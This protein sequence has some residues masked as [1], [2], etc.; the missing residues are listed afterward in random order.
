MSEFLSLDGSPKEHSSKYKS[1]TVSIIQSIK[2]S[3]TPSTTKKNDIH[4]N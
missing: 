3:N 1:N 4:I 2:T